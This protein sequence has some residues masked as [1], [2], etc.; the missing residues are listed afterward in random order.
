MPLSRTYRWASR[1]LLGALLLFFSITGFA[2]TAV[3][4]GGW[5]DG[6]EYLEEEGLI[7]FD[8][9]DTVFVNGT[10]GRDDVIDRDD[11]DTFAGYDIYQGDWGNDYANYGN[12]D[13]D[14]Y[15]DRTGTYYRWD[16][17]EENENEDN[18]NNGDDN[19]YTTPSPTNR[20][21]EI[22]YEDDQRYDEEVPCDQCSNIVGRQ[23]TVPVGYA[24]NSAGQCHAIT[25]PTDVCSNID[26]HQDYIPA[27]YVRG[28]A[29][30]C[31]PTPVCTTSGGSKGGSATVTCTCPSGYAVQGNQCVI[32][33]SSIPSCSISASPVTVESGGSSTLSWTSSHATTAVLNGGGNTNTP[34]A[35]A[36][37]APTGALTHNTTYTLTVTGPGGS[38]N[39]Q[40][41]IPVQACGSE[42]CDVCSNISGIQTS[43]PA[44][45]Q[46]IGDQCACNTGYI[47][48]GGVCVQSCANECV[49][50]NVVN[51]CTGAVVTI[52]SY[53]CSLGICQPPPSPNV[54][55]SVSPTLIQRG[56]TVNIT[57]TVVNAT[58]CRVVRTNGADWVGLSGTKTEQLDQETRYT[59]KCNALN[60]TPIE[61]GDTVKIVPVWQ[62]V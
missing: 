56:G 51:S 44:H 28:S 18:G 27:N 39:C 50:N 29:N 47:L 36:Q 54:T 40:T 2:Y 57:W 26:G 60:G 49:G 4:F 31:D 10:E 16:E 11:R 20:C 53:Q 59:L 23:D 7:V 38:A 42:G 22:Y 5:L 37:E 25:S 15:D 13:Y 48:Q 19:D 21:Y 43:P 1:L 8:T 55:W 58:N 24:K 46:I 45:S 52:C 41:T 30:E 62:E 9:G 12:L 61:F 33:G 32:P 3:A 14:Y 6:E 35:P 17:E 34:V